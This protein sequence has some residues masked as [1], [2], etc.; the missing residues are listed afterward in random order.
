MTAVVEDHDYLAFLLHVLSGGQ[1]AAGAFPTNCKKLTVR[2][3]H[4]V[5]FEDIRCGTVLCRGVLFV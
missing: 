4:R 2:H 5:R 1:Y 3:L